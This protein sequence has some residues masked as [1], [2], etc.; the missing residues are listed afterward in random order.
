M[1]KLL[2]Y[3]LLSIVAVFTM[4]S[5]EEDLGGG[6]IITNDP[7]ISLDISNT[8]LNPIPGQVISITVQAAPGDDDLQALT[9]QADGVNLAN[10]RISIDGSPA[11]ANPIL[12][13]SPDTDGFTWNIDIVAQSDPVV[14]TYTFTIRDLGG[15]TVSS[16]VDISTV[17]DVVSPTTISLYGNLM[18]MGT[19]GAKVK[20]PVSVIAGTYALKAIAVLDQDANPV[21]VSKLFYGDLSTNFTSN[22]MDI[23]ADDNLGFDVDIY[24][25]AHNGGIRTYTIAIEDVN[26]DVQF[27]D[28]TID[29]G[30]TVTSIMGVLFN[31][32]GPQGQGGLDL[33][34]G[35]SVGS[36]D[37]TAEIKD[38]GIDLD[39]PM[40][41]NWIRKISGANGAQLRHLIPNQNGLPESFTFEDIN[42]A[43]QIEAVWEN[44]QDF[45]DTNT[46]GDPISLKVELD[47]IYIVL[48]DGKYYLLKVVEINETLDSNADNYV[49]DIKY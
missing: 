25:T 31:A 39:E 23:A 18:Y 32:S 5:C 6:G 7:E 17:P 9:I 29:A 20:I 13:V 1:K 10:S 11:V 16:S 49:V 12:V 24:I 27:Q 37:A 35:E 26:G 2:L 28:F 19:P 36:N 38:E 15:N 14:V 33:D 46:V 40:D 41:K 45:V 21:D 48:K 22:P 44:G 8:N 30:T 4:S 47:D 43:D 34:T 42:V 3:S